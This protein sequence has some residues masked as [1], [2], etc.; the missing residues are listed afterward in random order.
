MKN[1]GFTLIEL[2]IV[3]AIIAIIA[4]IAIPN[5]VRSRMSANEGS[6]VSSMRMISTAEVA[7][8]AAIIKDTNGDGVGDYGVLSELGTPTA[9]PPFIGEALA[10]G[11]K[12]GYKF[13]VTVV[14]GDVSTYPT[15]TAT[16]EPQTTNTGS[17]YYFVDESGVI[18]AESGTPATSA[19][20][21]IS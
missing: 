12:S 18:R 6:A 2:M 16:G 14:D 11:T 19:S 20:P 10:S 1:Q 15:Y 7:Y 9:R 13:E 21:V 3:V 5:L 8:Q 17:K 4:A